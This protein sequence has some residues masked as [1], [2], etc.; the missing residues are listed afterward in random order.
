MVEI[1][2]AEKGLAPPDRM[3]WA[4]FDFVKIKII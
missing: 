1:W 4:Y 3:T 2:K